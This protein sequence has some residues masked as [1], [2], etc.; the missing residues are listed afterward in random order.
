[1]TVEETK[2]TDDDKEETVEVDK[3][4]N[5]MTPIWKKPKK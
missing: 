1:M 5:S 2:K 4:L 3:T